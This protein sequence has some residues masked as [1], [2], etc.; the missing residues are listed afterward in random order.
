[1]SNCILKPRLVNKVSVI[2]HDDLHSRRER[3]HDVV[4]DGEHG[5]HS[6]AV[7]VT[8]RGLARRDVRFATSSSATTS[9]LLSVR[10]GFIRRRST[11]RTRHP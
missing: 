7:C 9:R 2:G 1:M 8:D 10:A 11:S 4:H 5:Q 6:G 3:H